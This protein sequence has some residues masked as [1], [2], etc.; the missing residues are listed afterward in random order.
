MILPDANLLLYAYDEKSPYHRTAKAWW[1]HCL[2]GGEPVGLAEVV[3]FA[4]LR[5]S[6]HP[7]IYE[8]PMSVADASAA[9]ASWV[10]CPIVRILVPGENHIRDVVSLLE[11]AG[12]VGGN[13]VTDAQI[14]ALGIYHKAVIHTADRDFMRFRKAKLFFPL[15]TKP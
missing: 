1:E 8:S 15:D 5:V 6:T 14:A 9:I 13:L 4:F 2:S 10:E 3:V 7:R 11:E 12:S